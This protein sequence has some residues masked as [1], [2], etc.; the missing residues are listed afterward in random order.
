[1]VPPH[2]KLLPVEELG[3]WL[4]NGPTAVEIENGTRLAPQL[5]LKNHS[6]IRRTAQGGGKSIQSENASATTRLEATAVHLAYSL[7]GTTPELKG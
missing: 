1:M 4:L 6:N 7:V 2:H 5:P 3:R